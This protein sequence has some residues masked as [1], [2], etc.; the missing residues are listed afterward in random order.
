MNNNNKLQTYDLGEATQ[1]DNASRHYL[2]RYWQRK[3]EVAGL[4]HGPDDEVEIAKKSCLTFRS[5]AMDCP[6]FR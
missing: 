3:R 5:S 2:L 6:W 4:F 1:M